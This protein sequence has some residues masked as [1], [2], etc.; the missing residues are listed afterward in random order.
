VYVDSGTIGGGGGTLQATALTATST[1]KQGIELSCSTGLT[2]DASGNIN[3]CVAS[4]RSLKKDIQVLQFDPKLIDRL[5]PVSYLW[6]D[7]EKYDA[8]R[9]GGFIA[10]EL[11]I[12]DPLAVKSA[13]K[14]LL[15]IDNSALQADIVLDL[16]N[17]HKEIVAQQAEIDA[18][19]KQV[20]HV[21]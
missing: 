17:L 10:Q 13:G 21:Q 4:D 5:R 20:R 11:E 8:K 7:P 14:D 18:L 3:G 19:K 16:Q 9:H 6:K 1:I 2:T 15:G 12:V